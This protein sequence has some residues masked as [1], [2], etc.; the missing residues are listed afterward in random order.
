MTD[1]PEWKR[2]E[3]EAEIVNR[4]PSVGGVCKWQCETC[5]VV[6]YEPEDPDYDRMA[7]TT[8]WPVCCKSCWE[9]SKK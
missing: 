6:W 7:D 1:V 4:S 9:R 5:S 8:N 2:R 3:I